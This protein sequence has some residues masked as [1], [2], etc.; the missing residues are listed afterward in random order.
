MA[1]SPEAIRLRVRGRL[2]EQRVLVEDLLRQRE[3]LAGSLFVRFG[4][5]GKPGCV[6]RSGQKHGPYYVLSTRSGGRGGF[7]YLEADRLGEARELVRAYREYRAGMRRLRKV[8][9]QL[10]ALLRRYQEAT[11]RQG[12]RRVGLPAQAQA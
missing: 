5:C 11:S 8:N 7:A 6:C 1:L 3:Q 10:V 12:S 2:Q 4:L 9:E